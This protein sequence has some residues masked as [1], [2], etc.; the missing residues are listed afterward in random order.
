[1]GTSNSYGGSG[2]GNPLV[3]S[4]VS[5]VPAGPPALPPAPAPQ[6]PQNPPS[7]PPQNL[8][9]GPAAPNTQSERMSHREL[10]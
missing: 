8:P 3:P 9:G 4:W 7:Q 10:T 2:G 5:D 1:M 6:P